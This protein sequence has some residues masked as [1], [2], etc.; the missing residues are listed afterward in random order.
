MF[1]MLHTTE[2]KFQIPQTFYVHLKA[3]KKSEIIFFPLAYNSGAH[4]SAF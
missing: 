4:S 2:T 1:E 3:E